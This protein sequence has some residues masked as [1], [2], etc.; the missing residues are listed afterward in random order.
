MKLEEAASQGAL[1]ARLREEGRGRGHGERAGLGRRVIG[2][3][4]LS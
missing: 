3:N 1:S 4:E 2:S